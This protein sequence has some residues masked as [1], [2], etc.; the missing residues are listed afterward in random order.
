MGK[1][2][3]PLIVGIYSLEK[4][5]S[6]LKVNYYVHHCWIWESAQTDH[7]SHGVCTQP[8]PEVSPLLDGINLPKRH[9]LAIIGYAIKC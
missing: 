6:S 9:D 1:S 2:T 3:V 7:F 5:S 4:S 8:T